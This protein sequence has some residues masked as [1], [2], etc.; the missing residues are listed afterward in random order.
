ME[1]YENFIPRR[2]EIGGADPAM[3][4]DKLEAYENALRDM[5]KE[6]HIATSARRVIAAGLVGIGYRESPQLAE[7]L[8]WLLER[9]TD[10]LTAYS[11]YRAVM[12]T[13]PE[14]WK[15]TSWVNKTL[16]TTPFPLLRAVILEELLSEARVD[17]DDPEGQAQLALLDQAQPDHRALL[18]EYLWLGGSDSKCPVDEVVSMLRLDASMPEK[19]AAMRVFQFTDDVQLD[20]RAWPALMRLFRAEKHVGLSLKIADI[21]VRKHHFRLNLD[22]L[23]FFL[24]AR[25]ED[26]VVAAETAMVSMLFGVEDFLMD[27]ILPDESRKSA[28]TKA[29]LSFF[30]PERLPSDAKSVVDALTVICTDITEPFAAFAATAAL[31]ETG[32]SHEAG[33]QFVFQTAQSCDEPVARALAIRVLGKQPQALLPLQDEL[34][35]LTVAPG[36]DPRVRRAAFHALVYREQSGLSV[37]MVEVIDLYFQYLREAPFA[38][39]AD[40]VHVSDVAQEPAH[41][42]ARFAES[43]ALIPSQAARQAAFHLISNPF[44]FGLDQSFKAYWDQIVALMLIALDNPRHG[45]LH[46]AIFWNMLHEVAVPKRAAMVFSKGLKERQTHIKYTQRTRRLIE[47]W[48]QRHAKL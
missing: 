45:D 26:G 8:A 43:L 30:A 44:G 7:H 23:T 33:R 37:K 14:Y 35:A 42:V 18:A 17:F 2:Y 20:E 12:S 19:V 25:L 1:E 10:A 29:L 5:E 39:F 38:Q 15:L 31:A 3:G 40:A 4:M 32:H 46:Y 48:L 36:T 21:L 9:E 47:D 24:R 13:H 34:K 22:L 28:L 16:Q 6:V 41:F 11:L 27:N